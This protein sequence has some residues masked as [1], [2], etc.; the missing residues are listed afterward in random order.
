LPPSPQIGRGY[1]TRNDEPMTIAAG[2]NM[3]CHPAYV[4]AGAWNW[5]CDNFFVGDNG[6]EGRVHKTEQKIFEL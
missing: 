4:S 1:A 3:A 2:M 5:V 6:V